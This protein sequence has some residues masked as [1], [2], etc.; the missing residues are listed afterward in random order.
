[1]LQG[2]L[3]YVEDCPHLPNLNDSKLKKQEY[4]I[5]T[6]VIIGGGKT[7]INH[8]EAVIEYSAGENALIIHSSLKNVESYK[9]YDGSQVACLVGN[10]ASKMGNAEK[11]VNKIKAFIVSSSSSTEQQLPEPWQNKAF[12]VDTL[13]PTSNKERHSDESPLNLSLS[14]ACEMKVEKVLLVGFD[15]YPAEKV[16]TKAL[17]EEV[18]FTIDRFLNNYPK[19]TLCSI[20]QTLYKVPQSSVYAWLGNKE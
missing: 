18:Q 5:K 9:D 17:A 19:I 12:S 10:E 3:S 6:A 20:T 16:E 13:W 15:G 7:A 14:I 4:H 1:M 8:N 2:N 11:D